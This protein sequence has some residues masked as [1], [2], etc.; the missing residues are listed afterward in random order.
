MFK[1]DIFHLNVTWNID[2]QSLQKYLL[3]LSLQ[4]VVHN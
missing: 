3:D 4:W 1:M 2:T